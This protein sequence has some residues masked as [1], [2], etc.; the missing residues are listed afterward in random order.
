MPTIRDPATRDAL[1]ARV[2]RLTP[3]ATPHWGRMTAGQM[4]AHLSDSARMA[5]GEI[6][7]APRNVWLTQTAMFK[8]VFLNVMPF[9]K[10]APSAK[11]IVSRTPTSFEIER[12][13]LKALTARLTPDALAAASA[14]HALFGKLTPAEWAAL[15]H[16]H[17]DHH[18][19]QFG[20]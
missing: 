1:L 14:A 18:L 3:D 6:T 11:E 9:P 5:L 7:V 16:K 20:V 13:T 8:F 4:L 17:M 15:A 2:D 19:R 12:D 10:N